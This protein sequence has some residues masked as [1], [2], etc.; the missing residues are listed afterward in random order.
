MKEVQDQYFKY[1][2][3]WIED[4]SDKGWTTHY[5]PVHPPLSAEI[6]AALVF[7]GGFNH[8][9]EC[10]EFD[11]EACRWRF[12]PFETRGDISWGGNA[13]AAHSYFDAHTKEFSAGVEQLLSSHAILHAFG[14]SFLS[15]KPLVEGVTNQGPPLLQPVITRKK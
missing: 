7:V 10:P 5:R 2:F 8:F 4:G 1:K 3:T 15:I 9:P 13:E 14:I 12:M 11:F 6:E